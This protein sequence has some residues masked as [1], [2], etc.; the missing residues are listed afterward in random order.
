[1]IQLLGKVSISD[2]LMIIA[3]LSGPIAAVQV[4]EILARRK[5]ARNRQLY[6]FRV[7]MATRATRLSAQ[8]V[9]ALNLIDIDFYGVK[10]IQ[11]LWHEYLDSLSTKNLQ[12][13]ALS[14]KQMD[15][16]VDLMHEMAVFLGYEFDKVA[17]RNSAYYP[18]GHGKVEEELNTIRGKLV[19][20]LTDKSALP[21]KVRD[22]AP[23]SPNLPG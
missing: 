12:T 8:H 17:V 9:E 23:P 6:I 20:L 5:E 3:V 15:L 16:F 10:K 21:I 1:M 11:D 18:V 22:Q 2:W 7:L 13:D 14:A 19:E 4:S